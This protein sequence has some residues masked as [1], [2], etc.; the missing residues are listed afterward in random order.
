MKFKNEDAED[1]K[2]EAASK[3]CVDGVYSSS[4]NKVKN[5][6]KDDCDTLVKQEDCENQELINRKR[7]RSVDAK[8]SFDLPEALETGKTTVK[9]EEPCDMTTTGNEQSRTELATENC[10]KQKTTATTA[11]VKASG[12]EVVEGMEVDDDD[13]SQ[14][15]GE[16]FEGF[17]SQITA[18]AATSTAVGNCVNGESASRSDD[19]TLEDA[20]STGAGGTVSSDCKS[21]DNGAEDV[22]NDNSSSASVL[23]PTGITDDELELESEAIEEEA[24]SSK[25]I[26]NKNQMEDDED[27][28]DWGDR[29]GGGPRT[30]EGPAPS[31]P[32]HTEEEDCRI[33]SASPFRPR[34]PPSPQPVSA[35]SSFSLPSILQDTP[36]ITTLGKTPPLTTLGN[37]PLS[38]G[39]FA[40]SVNHPHQLKTSA[41]TAA[42]FLPS[43]SSVAVSICSSSLGNSSPV[44]G[45]SDRLSVFRSTTSALSSECG[46][47]MDEG[48]AMN[49]SR[50]SVGTPS[51]AS[52]NEDLP[53]TTLG[54]LD[55]GKIPLTSLIGDRLSTVSEES[56]SRPGSASSQSNKA[57]PPIKRKLSILEYRKRKSVNSESEASSSPSRTTAP[58]LTTHASELCPITSEFEN[59]KQQDSATVDSPLS[60]SRVGGVEAAS[61]CD[62]SD[63]DEARSLSPLATISSSTASYL[64]QS[65]TGGA[66]A[67][68]NL[69]YNVSTVASTSKKH[70]NNSNDEDDDYINEELLLS[71]VNKHDTTITSGE[72]EECGNMTPSCSPP[73][74]PSPGTPPPPPPPP[75]EDDDDD[76]AASPPPPPPSPLPDSSPSTTE[77]QP[78]F[79]PISPPS[80][81]RLSTTIATAFSASPY[82]SLNK[83]SPSALTPPATSYRGT[84]E[85]RLEKEFGLSVSGGVTSTSSQARGSDDS[86][87]SC[88]VQQQQ[89]PY[90]SL[91][92]TL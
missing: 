11:V 33:S 75:A 38:S 45:I 70:D 72:D 89:Q 24:V 28:M 59:K 6:K 54:R 14:E 18:A 83:G 35:S 40:S 29:G 51:S 5:E 76:D 55:T 39:C 88:R 65:T 2:F 13:D 16:G 15:S 58:S 43:G 17:T 37:T 74:P 56:S 31:S 63:D 82:S 25:N 34:T 90:Y 91:S 57:P 87:S 52:F 3:T 73:S 27:G 7:K 20:G 81:P 46:V 1:I 60:N 79:P 22:A 64:L 19:L 44:L 42:E 36:S 78:S 71:V 86:S 23:K 41:A 84:L 92:P 26:D 62:D 9:K 77:H 47:G 61:D 50:L 49:A 53:L 4:H 21:E 67:V 32:F 69:L 10:D 66:A 30:P 48:A 8:V 12:D 80:S 85:D 68:N